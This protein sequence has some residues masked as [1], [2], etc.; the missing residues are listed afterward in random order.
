MDLKADISKMA[1]LP[2]LI[3]KFNLIPIKISALLHV[4]RQAESKMYMEGQRN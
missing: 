3:Y 4:N 1:I 2:K